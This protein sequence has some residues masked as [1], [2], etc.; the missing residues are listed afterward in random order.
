M[1]SVVCQRPG[2]LLLSRH[3]STP[4]P[5]ND[6][7]PKIEIRTEMITTK[8]EKV[9]APAEREAAPD[10][11]TE[12]A[13]WHGKEPVAEGASSAREIG[14]PLPYRIDKLNVKKWG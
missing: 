12:S 7:S 6:R 1:I 13:Y 8:A 14:W 9:E 10:T 3:P 5:I 2:W 11:P 4:L